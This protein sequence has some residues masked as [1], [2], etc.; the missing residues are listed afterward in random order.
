MQ[1]QEISAA[2]ESYGYLV[3]Q[4][5]T[6]SSL[7]VPQTYKDLHK[8]AVS[9]LA[10]S[11]LEP[12]PEKASKLGLDEE[13]YRRKLAVRQSTPDLLS[14]NSTEAFSPKGEKNAWTSSLKVPKSQAQSSVNVLQGQL[15]PHPMKYC[16]NK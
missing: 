8:R 15:K 2:A 4:R 12:V 16:P 13:F 5:K 10:V 7:L 1:C 9:A 14:R 6:N 11:Q 3:P